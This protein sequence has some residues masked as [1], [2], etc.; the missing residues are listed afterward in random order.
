S[1]RRFGIR[2]VN[3]VF[4][5]G[6][7]EISADGAGS[8]VFRV[9]RAHQ[10]TVSQNSVFAFQNLNDNWTGS[11]ECNQVFEEAT[12]AVLSVEAS[13]LALGQLKHFRSNDAQAGFFE[14]AGDFA[15][16]VFS[17]SFRLDDGGSALNSHVELQKQWSSTWLFNALSPSSSHVDLQ[18]QWLERKIKPANYTRVYWDYLTAYRATQ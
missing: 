12:L 1:S 3:G 9:S 17:N 4:V 10:I 11:H 14:T 7:G 15:D 6:Y 13:S 18:K 2:T 5:D 8:C 16:N